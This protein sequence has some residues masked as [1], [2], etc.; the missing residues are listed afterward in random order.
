MSLDRFR[1]DNDV[2][3][4]TG[5]SAGLGRAIAVAVAQVGAKV[6][7][8]ARRQEMLLEVRAEIEASGGECHT[9]VVD[10]RSEEQCDAAV[11]SAVQTFGAV[12]VLINNAGVARSALALVEPSDDFFEVVDV[13]LIGAYRMSQAFARHCVDRGHGG[14]IVN[15]GSAL[16]LHGWSSPQASYSASKAGL[17][18]L[19]RDLSQQWAGRYGIRVNTVAPGFFESEMTRD[20]ADGPHAELVREKIGLGR[21]GATDE[22]IGPVLLLASSAGA[23]M[24]GTTVVVDGGW[25]LH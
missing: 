4:V 16:G 20:M 11:Q 3:L 10:V 15:I 18:G 24:T 9:H 17:L 2:V 7:A 25:T 1:M 8:C 13:N 22:V 5:A 6:V 19:T 21:L 14:S 12:T 23:Y